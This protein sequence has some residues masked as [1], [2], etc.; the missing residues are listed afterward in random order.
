MATPLNCK[1]RKNALI[2]QKLIQSILQSGPPGINEARKLMFASESKH[3]TAIP[4]TQGALKEHIK[5]SA[6]I[7]G[8][9]W[10]CASNLTGTN[11]SPEG[12]GWTQTAGEWNV[13][14][15]K[16]PMVWKAIHTL[17]RCGCGTG[18]ETLRCRCLRHGLPCSP[19]CRKCMGDCAN[20]RYVAYR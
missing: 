20:K 19:A 4:P 3:L 12:W 14:W 18:C 1:K 9:M 2:Q 11:T 17:D 7:A 15:T 10:G 16:L 8:H 13:V 6:F 5:R